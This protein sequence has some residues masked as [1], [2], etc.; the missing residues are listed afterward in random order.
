MTRTVVSPARY[1]ETVTMSM[2]SILEG[3]FELP[4]EIKVKTEILT[5]VCGDADVSKSLIR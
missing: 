3:W 5:D 4:P 1:L 2:Q